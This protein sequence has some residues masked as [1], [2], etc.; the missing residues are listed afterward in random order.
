MKEKTIK[1]NDSW[2]FAI[3]NGRL[4]EIYFKKKYGIYGHC[5]IKKREY[6]KTEQRMID[7]DI[8]KC[9]FIFRKGYYFDKKRGTKTLSNPIKA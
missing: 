3:V 1:F 8:K 7:T 9:Q 4:A 2:C 6:N 5:Y